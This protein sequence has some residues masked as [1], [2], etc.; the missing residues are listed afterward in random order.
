MFGVCKF[1]TSLHT[2]IIK[3][4]LMHKL[5]ASCLNCKIVLRKSNLRLTR[6]AILRNKVAGIA[7]Q[8]NVIYLTLSTFCEFYHFPG[9]GKMI[10]YF[11]SCILT[12][13]FSTH[14]HIFESIPFCITQKR[15]KF[16]CTPTFHSI[17]LDGDGFETIKQILYLVCLHISTYSLRIQNY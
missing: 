4:S 1:G 9:V 14:K 13:F 16:A 17:K 10:G 15:I 11:F 5:C 3:K 12:G 8:H 6:V 2:F 7:R